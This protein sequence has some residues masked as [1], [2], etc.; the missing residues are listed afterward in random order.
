M[1]QLVTP[2]VYFVGA[3]EVREAGLK[4]YLQDTKQMEFWDVYRQARDEGL[5]S[6]EALCSVYAKICYKS[7]V[8]GKNSNVSKIRDVRNNL[9][10]CHDTGHGAIFEHCQLN[11]LVTNCSRVFTHEQVRQR[12]GWAYSQTSGRYC[13]LDAIDLVWSDLLDPVKELWLEHLKKTEDLVYLTECKLGLRKPPTVDPNAK[14]E[15]CLVYRDKGVSTWHQHQWQ[16]DNSFDFDKRKAITS[17]VRRI[18]PNGQANEIGMSC[19]IRALRHVVQL[20]TAKFAETEIRDVYAQVFRLVKDEFP[21]IFY[22]ARTRLHNGIPEVFGMRM[23]PYEIEAGDP[24][25]LEYWDS[26]SLRAE[27]E[28]R[29]ELVPQA[30]V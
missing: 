23:Q 16:P 7:M 19:N 14:P 27:M 2:K 15:D 5:H 30:K 3:T 10:G 4:E 13:R 24:K 9:E 25:A 20:R 28:K 22:K 29:G 11:F 17:A 21:T 18:A 8:L 12:V 1:G 6:G 26:A